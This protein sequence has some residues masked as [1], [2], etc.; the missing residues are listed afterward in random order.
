MNKMGATKATRRV[1][2]VFKLALPH[3]VTGAL[4]PWMDEG[5]DFGDDDEVNEIL[6]GFVLI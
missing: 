5:E 6:Q 2:T 3:M 1:T 4:A